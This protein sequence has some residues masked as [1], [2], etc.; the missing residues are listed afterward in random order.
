MTRAS[1]MDVILRLLL[2]PAAFKAINPQAS[3]PLISAQPLSKHQSR[4]FTLSVASFSLYPWE[5]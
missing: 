3:H 2:H 5:R 1:N 4:L